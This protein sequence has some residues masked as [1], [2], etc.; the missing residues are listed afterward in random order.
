MES[1]LLNFE[2]ERIKREVGWRRQMQIA[3]KEIK[4]SYLASAQGEDS[5]DG[6]L[7]SLIDEIDGEYVSVLSTYSH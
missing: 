4:E 3:D 1:E 2:D 7:T 6:T 5:F